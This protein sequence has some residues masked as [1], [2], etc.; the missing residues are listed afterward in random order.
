MQGWVH[1]RQHKPFGDHN[2]SSYMCPDCSSSYKSK[3]STGA[4]SLEHVI[5]CHYYLHTLHYS[6]LLCFSSQIFSW[7]ESL[8]FSVLCIPTYF[9]HDIILLMINLTYICDRIIC[10]KLTYLINSFLRKS[11]E[12]IFVSVVSIPLYL[13]GNISI[14]LSTES[15]FFHF[16]YYFFLFQTPKNYSGSDGAKKD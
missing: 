13:A 14:M 3:A 6:S 7:L 9:I 12:F 11:E 15:Y 4:S 1:W 16:T 10:M 8:Y 2:G 5:V